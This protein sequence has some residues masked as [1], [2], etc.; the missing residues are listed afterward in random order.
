MEAANVR[1]CP[2]PSTMYTLYIYGSIWWHIQPS[3]EY[4]GPHLSDCRRVLSICHAYQQ[5][6]KRNC[7]KKNTRKIIRCNQQLRCAVLCLFRLRLSIY[8]L[9]SLRTTNKN[10]N[11]NTNFSKD[12]NFSG[13]LKCWQ[14]PTYSLAP[15]ISNTLSIYECVG[16]SV[17]VERGESM[18]V[19]WC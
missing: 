11:N 17:C 2:G 3:L 1:G 16:V 8:L 7:E 12:N 6:L 19:L 9:N 15:F 4:F 14:Q 10:N 18:C 5:Q 13:N